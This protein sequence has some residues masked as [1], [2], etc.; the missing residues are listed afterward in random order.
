MRRFGLHVALLA[1]LTL[2]GA[3]SAHAELG[4]A[5]PAEGENVITMPTEVALTFTEP[6]EV[7]FSLFKV[8]PLDA[9]VN[10]AEE[11]AQQRLNGLAGQLVSEV[12]EAQGDDEV[13][14]DVGISTTERSSAEVTLRL[15]DT[16]ESGPY[17][18]MWR[19]ISADTHPV[20]GFYTFVYAPG[21]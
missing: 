12:L 1:V 5:S 7:R 3:A 21:E 8:Y 16:L 14:A 2:I 11:N 17:V 10:M 15:K 4:S 9:D 19:V 6:V 20:E 13:K 18:V